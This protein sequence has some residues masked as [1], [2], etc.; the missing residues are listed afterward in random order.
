MQRDIAWWLANMS[1]SWSLDCVVP[2]DP[3]EVYPHQ[4]IPIQVGE[5]VHTVT[6]KVKRV[7]Y[8]ISFI[9]FMVYY[10]LYICT[11]FWHCQIA[12]SELIIN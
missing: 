4:S 6:A 2:R 3:T 7:R 10:T 9:V 8:I 1:S 11:F 5:K 12:C